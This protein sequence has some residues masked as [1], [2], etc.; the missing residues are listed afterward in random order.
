[1][2]SGLIIEHYFTIIG[3]I[4]L[5]HFKFDIIMSI[6]IYHNSEIPTFSVCALLITV[7]DHH[8]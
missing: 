6:T 3:I 1:M 5:Y 8:K 2:E 7:Y 4:A